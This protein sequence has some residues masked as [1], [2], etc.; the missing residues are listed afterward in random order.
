MGSLWIHSLWKD[1]L[2]HP[3]VKVCLCR[4]LLKKCVLYLKQ[5]TI[6]VYPE[7][8]DRFLDIEKRCTELRELAAECGMEN[9]ER[10]KSLEKSINSLFT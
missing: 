5:I 9:Q 7:E 3:E 1:G 8:G 10:R 2:A 6:E 4:P